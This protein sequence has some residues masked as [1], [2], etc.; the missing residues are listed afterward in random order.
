MKKVLFTFLLLA[1]VSLGF[2]S[3]SD[4]DNDNEKPV[5]SDFEPVEGDSLQIGKAIHFEVDF[6]DN[7]KL[8]SYKIDIHNNFNNHGDHSSVKSLP[9]DSAVFAF[10]DVYTDIAGQK[11][12]H[13]HHHKINIPATDANGKPYRVGKYHFVVYCLDESGNESVRSHN[14]IL[15]YN[16]IKDHTEDGHDH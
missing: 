12:A 1:S 14:V 8:A 15:T 2:S 9:I 10:S 4:D 11:N 5:I 7:D 3:C 6:S 13:V 16:A